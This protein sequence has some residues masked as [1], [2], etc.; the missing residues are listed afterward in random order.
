MDRLT[1]ISALKMMNYKIITPIDKYPTKAYKNNI[2]VHIYNNNI[3]VRLGSNTTNYRLNMNTEEFDI[4]INSKTES[5]YEYKPSTKHPKY[6]RY[7]PNA[8]AKAKRYSCTIKT[9]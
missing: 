5:D 2:E 9:S 6:E 3:I 4:F 7:Y 1:F 8:K